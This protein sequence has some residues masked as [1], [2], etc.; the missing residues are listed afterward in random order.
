[1]RTSAS[2]AFLKLFF[3]ALAIL[4]LCLSCKTV[5]VTRVSN[6][7]SCGPGGTATQHSQSPPESCPLYVKASLVP[8]GAGDTAGHLCVEAP[9][10]YKPLRQ[11][12]QCHCGGAV[13]DTYA[14]CNTACPASLKCFAG[15]YQLQGK[16]MQGKATVNWVLTDT[17]QFNDWSP[18]PPDLADRACTAARDRYQAAVAAHEAHHVADNTRIVTQWNRQNANQPAVEATSCAADPEADID[19]QIKAQLAAQNKALHAQ[20]AE[21]AAAFHATPEGQHP[22]IDC[23]DCPE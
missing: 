13:F 1:M 9:T 14:A 20:M 3:L 5:P 16:C 7:S 2:R 19:N 12:W 23:T 21:A 11:A 4:P 15:C 6:A 8:G 18:T 10:Q 17:V 22:A